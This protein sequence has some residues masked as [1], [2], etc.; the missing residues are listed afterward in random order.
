MEE[1][2]KLEDC[3]DVDKEASLIIEKLACEEVLGKEKN[4]GGDAIDW[5]KMGIGAYGSLLSGTVGLGGI[6]GALAWSAKKNNL[7]AE[8]RSSR[9]HKV[10]D[11]YI[12]VELSK[13]N[14]LQ[15]RI[16]RLKEKADKQGYGAKN[17]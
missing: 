11:K 7:I 15:H 6:L 9:K 12:F 1:L 14:I 16:D 3:I 13:Q 17:A 10:Y 5:A 8:H 2:L 4:A